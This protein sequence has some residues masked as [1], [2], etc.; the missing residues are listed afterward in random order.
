[1]TAER[2][3]REELLELRGEVHNPPRPRARSTSSQL[4]DAERLVAEGK[5]E[6]LERTTRRVVAEVDGRSGERR[7]V[8][9][10]GGRWSCDCPAFVQR[11]RCAHLDAVQLVV[12]EPGLRR[13]RP[14]T[15]QRAQLELGGGTS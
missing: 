6:I 11:R 7:R 5:V 2:I 10:D 9:H 4:S 15:Q 13:L 1:M 12:A 3:S 14:S 8:L